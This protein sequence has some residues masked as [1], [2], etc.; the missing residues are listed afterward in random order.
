MQF[1]LRNDFVPLLLRAPVRQTTYWLPTFSKSL[2]FL[3]S[4]AG[5]IC[6]VPHTANALTHNSHFKTFLSQSCFLH[7][8]LSSLVPNYGVLLIFFGVI[9][10]RA[11]GENHRMH[12]IWI[13]TWFCNFLKIVY[14]VNFSQRKDTYRC[15]QNML[16]KK[17][18]REKERCQEKMLF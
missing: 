5:R 8:C 9:C 10:K 14:T 1:S 16:F 7:V 17:Q 18:K 2:F 13:S 6:S 3:F 12:L 15:K 4:P 11:V